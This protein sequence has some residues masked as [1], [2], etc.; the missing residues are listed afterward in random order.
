[1]STTEEQ[2]IEFFERLGE[3]CC[4]P[5]AAEA[6]QPAVERLLSAIDADFQRTF[7]ERLARVSTMTPGEK[8]ALADDIKNYARALRRELK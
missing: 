1:M 5:I 3:R 6:Y 4:K 8:L 7:A 2:E